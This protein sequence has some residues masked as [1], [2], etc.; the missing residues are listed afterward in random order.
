MTD[1]AATPL[2]R[3]ASAM[4]ALFQASG[5]FAFRAVDRRRRRLAPTDA[6]SKREEDDGDD[7]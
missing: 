2:P 4:S 5:F 7:D 3:R 6:L 1:E